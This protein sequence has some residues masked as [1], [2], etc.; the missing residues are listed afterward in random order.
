MEKLRKYWR[1]V[2]VALF[3]VFSIWYLVSRNIK[4]KIT[5]QTTPVTK[6]TIVS[7]V[8][9]SGQI[10]TSNLINVSTQATGIVKTVYVT[11]GEIVKRGQVIAEIILDSD[12]ALANAKAWQTLI[13]A[14]NSYRLTQASL[15]NVYDQIK[16]HDNDETFT[17]KETRTRAEVANDNTFVALAFVALSYRQTSPIIVSPMTGMIDNITVTPG[18]V[19]TG[20]N[21]VAVITSKGNPLATFNVSEVDVNRVKQG[22][23]ATITLDSLSGK[24]FTGKIMTVDKVG[25][26]ASGVTNYPVVVLFDTTVPEILPNMAATANIII[27]SKDSVLMVPLSAIQTQTNESSYVKILKNKRPQNVIIETGLSSDTE[28]EVIS[29]VNEGDK[30]IT[31]TASGISSGVSSTS[32]FSTFR[33]RSGMR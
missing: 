25:T 24:T 9:A 29:G 32:P 5:Y 8:S 17:Q 16:G 28:T 12:G 18:M 21:R 3:L 6:G 13:S 10:L 23:K 31:G 33:V 22:Q 15:A 7:S 1:L 14:Q 27:D 20:T 11:D 19:L 4:N 2:L 26:V 30:V